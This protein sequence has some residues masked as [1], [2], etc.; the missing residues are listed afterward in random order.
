MCNILKQLLQHHL[1]SQTYWKWSLQWSHI[2]PS[3]NLKTI[4]TTVIINWNFHYN[5]NN[6]FKLLLQHHGMSIATKIMYKKSTVRSFIEIRVSFP[7]QYQ[8]IPI[9]TKL[10]LKN[11][12][13]NIS[14]L[15]DRVFDF[16]S[17]LRIILILALPNTMMYINPSKHTAQYKH[18]W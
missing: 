17:E 15:V 2:H 8:L 18:T 6:Q 9:V 3:N 14:M 13:P 4:I 10:C 16:F 11:P 12:H 1:T 5:S 7:L